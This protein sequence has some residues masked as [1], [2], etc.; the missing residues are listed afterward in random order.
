[1]QIEME[2]QNDQLK[3][4]SEI[5]SLMESS[6]RFLSLS[7]LSGIFAGC[8][9]LLGAVAAFLF[10]NL[11]LFSNDYYHYISSSSSYN[12]PALLFFIADALTVLLLA[13]LVGTYFTSRNA[14][15]K[16]QPIWDITV[17]KLLLNLLIPLITGGLF[18]FVLLFHHL[19]YLIAPVMLIFY[20]LALV[21]ASKFTF[22]M[23]KYLGL[24]EILLGIIACFFIGY[25]LLFWAL[26]FGVLH[27][28]YG[29]LMYN[30]YER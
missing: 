30:K 11:G 21:N 29:A 20:G 19:V 2:E 12:M 3:A 8:F 5:R 15:K 9:G 10:L 26:G 7:G 24:S 13:L 22:T 1:M 28:I 27:I 17:K 14:R 25:G 23:V 18:C 6:T 16:G 4:L